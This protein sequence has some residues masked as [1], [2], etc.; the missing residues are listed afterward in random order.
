ML[1]LMLLAFSGKIEPGE[2]VY[3]LGAVLAFV[4][5]YA[6]TVYLWDR[7][8]RYSTRDWKTAVATVDTVEYEQVAGAK[9]GYSMRLTVHYTYIAA[10]ERTGS[11]KFSKELYDSAR[12]L[13]E[14]LPGTEFNIRYDPKNEASS[15]VLLGD[16]PD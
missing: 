16:R 1:R 15:V 2:F 13:A 11:Y 5:L 3:V 14:S 7:W 9:G 6:L 10:S 8:K 4:A 12:S